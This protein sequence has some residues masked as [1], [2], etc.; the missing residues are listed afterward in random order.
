[1]NNT[2]LPGMLEINANHGSVSSRGC[3]FDE[4]RLE[5]TTSSQK[6]PHEPIRS[7]L[8]NSC[9]TDIDK[10][11]IVKQG[12]NETLIRCF[13]LCDISTELLDPDDILKSLNVLSKGIVRDREKK[14]KHYI[15]RKETEFS[16]TIRTIEGELV[17][18]R[19]VG[20]LNIKNELLASKELIH[21]SA[22]LEELRLDHCKL[23]TEADVLDMENRMLRQRLWETQRNN[24]NSREKLHDTVKT[25]NETTNVN[26]T[27]LKQLHDRLKSKDILLSNFEKEIEKFKV[28]KRNL[29]SIVKSLERDRGNRNEQVEMLHYVSN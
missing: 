11:F 1:M 6:N 10:D 20:T 26:V 27:Y 23:K 5:G 7:I 12:I 3:T 18:N 28:E 19:L 8:K 21:E 13:N 24:E 25:E 17:K 22:K 15:D 29:L 9:N 4:V 2:A 16:K 14:I